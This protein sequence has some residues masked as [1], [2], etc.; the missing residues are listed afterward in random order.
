[1]LKSIII[2][3]CWR[4]NNVTKVASLEGAISG[5][6]GTNYLCEESE[7]LEASIEMLHLVEVHDHLKMRVVDVRIHPEEAL[8]DG[9][10][11]I[12]EVGRERNPCTCIC[13]LAP[14]FSTKILMY[15]ILIRL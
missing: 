2:N 12:T 13:L 11:D 1:M 7:V 4:A 6:S 3:K 10:D 14:H 8:Q 9:P 5:R 15:M